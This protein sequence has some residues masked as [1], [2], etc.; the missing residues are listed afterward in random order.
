MLEAGRLVNRGL[1]PVT[2]SN[3]FRPQ[4]IRHTTTG[5]YTASL[6]M[7]IDGSFPGVKA[8]DA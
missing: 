2:G 8:A 1:I 5:T 6:S 7:D 4:I 3:L